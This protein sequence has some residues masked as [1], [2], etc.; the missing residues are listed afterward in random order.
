VDTG[1]ELG[2]K[3]F[4]YLTHDTDRKYSM[5]RVDQTLF[6]FLYGPGNPCFRRGDHRVP[7]GRPPFYLVAEG[8]WRGNPRGTPAFRHRRVEDWVDEFANHQNSIAAAI[9]RG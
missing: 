1:T 4:Y 9:K 5:Q 7:I 3:Q 6:K 8:D 2:Q